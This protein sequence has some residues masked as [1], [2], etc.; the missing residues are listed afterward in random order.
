MEG[1]VYRERTAVIE[2]E[3]LDVEGVGVG[4]E[5]AREASRWGILWK[6]G[7]D[8]RL[9]RWR[10]FEADMRQIAVPGWCHVVE[11]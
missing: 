3:F 8:S 2:V 5:G 7:A 6:G 10:C 11:P 4:L 1:E 9:E